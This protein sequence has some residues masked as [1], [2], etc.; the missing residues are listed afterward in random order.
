MN[1]NELTFGI[2]IE[3][4]APTSALVNDGLRIGPYKHGIQVPYLGIDQTTGQ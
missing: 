4:I 2:E 3:T 1:A